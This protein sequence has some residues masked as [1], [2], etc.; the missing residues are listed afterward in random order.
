MLSAATSR[1]DRRALPGGMPG[2]GRARDRD[3]RANAKPHAVRPF[4]LKICHKFIA[5]APE[6]SV[7]H[8]SK[9]TAHLLPHATRGHGDMARTHCDTVPVQSLIACH[10]AH[11]SNANWPPDM[12][13]VSCCPRTT[14]L[15]CDLLLEPPKMFAKFQTKPTT[16]L[17]GP[18]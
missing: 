18:I 10:V 7:P 4:L 17:L 5:F 12:P 15:V 14:Q 11:I 1:K 6:F 8:R 9:A 3:F 16:T 13:D 2:G